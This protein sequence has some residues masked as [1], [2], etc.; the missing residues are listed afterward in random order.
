VIRVGKN[1]KGRLLGF[2]LG[3]VGKGRSEKA[4]ANSVKAIEARNAGDPDARAIDPL[5]G[6]GQPA[7]A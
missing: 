4:F 6:V 1:A 5:I 2:V 3:T 7:G